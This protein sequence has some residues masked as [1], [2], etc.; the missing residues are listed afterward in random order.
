MK[1]LIKK[2]SLKTKKN[3]NT[4][5]LKTKK[6]SR[7]KKKGGGIINDYEITS[8]GAS[9]KSFTTTIKL[10][11]I[12]T[13]IIYIIPEQII[14][15]VSSILVPMFNIYLNSKETTKCNLKIGNKYIDYFVKI[16]TEWYAIVRIFGI[17]GLNTGVFATMTN[18]VFFKLNKDSFVF[19]EQSY[20]I[21]I[22]K[23]KYKIL[24]NNAT[25]FFRSRFNSLLEINS[26]QFS[27][28]EA[29]DEGNIYYI[30]RKFRN[31]QIVKEKVKE[32]AAFKIGE[33]ALGL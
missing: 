2:K 6:S 23:S 27:S 16:G 1:G 12:S 17:L 33:G 11:G 31:E 26:D 28:V 25:G 29:S 10:K 8:L 24:E 9:N 5:N 18:K 13:K 32:K 14:R 20:E 4:N 7:R 21:S 15:N 22:D 30:L 3:L 19:N